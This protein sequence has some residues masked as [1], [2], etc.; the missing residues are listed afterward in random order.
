MSKSVAILQS[1]YIPWKGY[2][3]IIRHADIFVIYD[4]AQYTKNDWRNR[5]QIKTA[6]GPQWLTIP[7]SQ[8]SLQQK[9]YETEIASDN[10]TKKHWNAILTNYSKAEH[11]KNYA[12]EL[13]TIYQ[14][15][16]QEKLLS[17]VNLKLIKFI[18]K[19]LEIDT[20]IIDSRTIDKKTENPTER[21][22]EICHELGATRY[23]SGPRGQNYMETELFAGIEILWMDYS[24]YPEY[25]QLFSDFTHQVTALDLIFNTGLEAKNY[26]SPKIRC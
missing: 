13:E 9:I 23:I 14:E 8:K 3:D 12:S 4:E 11:F 26:L 19:A 15:L 25:K 5:N 10:W 21:L 17:T 20:Q 6:Q 18:N 1:N 16:A 7:V 24:N 2:F 22:V